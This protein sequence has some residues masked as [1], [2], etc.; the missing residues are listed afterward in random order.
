MHSQHGQKLNHDRHAKS[1][2]FHL[3]DHVFVRNFHGTPAWL[4]GIV[5]SWIGPLSIR[6]QLEDGREWRHYINHVRVRFDVSPDPV[7][8]HEETQ[9]PRPDSTTRRENAAS[10]LSSLIKFFP[11]L[12]IIPVG[13]ASNA[14]INNAPVVEKAIS[15]EDSLQQSIDCKLRPVPNKETLKGR[16][17]QHHV[18]HQHLM[19]RS[20]LFP[21]H[22]PIIH[23]AVHSVIE[24]R[25]SFTEHKEGEM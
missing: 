21:Y 9:A 13:G 10:V 22:T 25:Q 7:P 6:A 11:E 8:A 20:H 17:T 15:P 24:T 4:P 1:R 19:M 18:P 23:S 5:R 16:T 12:Q 3:G 14:Q 2:T